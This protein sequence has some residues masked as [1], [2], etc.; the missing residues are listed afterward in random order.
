MLPL[1][2]R[3]ALKALHPV[4]R[5]RVLVPPDRDADSEV[6]VAFLANVKVLGGVAEH[7]ARL[8]AVVAR[9]LGLG[10]AGALV[11]LLA[12][13]DHRGGGTLVQDNGEWL[14]QH[15]A[16][17][18]LEAGLAHELELLSALGATVLLVELLVV[19]EQLLESFSHI[20]QS[21]LALVFAGHLSVSSTFRLIHI[22]SAFVPQPVL[23]AESL[24]P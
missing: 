23:L 22:Y 18:R 7:S 14:G 15:Q 1:L 17:P 24:A 11:R 20:E 2:A 5:E 8:T 21:E 19:V 9:Q 12:D 6:V 3:V 13:S 4:T 16:G 10:L